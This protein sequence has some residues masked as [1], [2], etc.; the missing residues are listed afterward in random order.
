MTQRVLKRPRH[1]WARKPNQDL[2]D[3]IAFVAMLWGGAMF[4]QWTAWVIDALVN[5]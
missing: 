3:L 1:G 2:P 4:F 5:I